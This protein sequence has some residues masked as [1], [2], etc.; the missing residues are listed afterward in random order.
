M[1]V[2]LIPVP[3][4]SFPH[5]KVL[6]EKQSND[7]GS[8]LTTMQIY[9]LF[10]TLFVCTG[11]DAHLSAKDFFT[12]SMS[13]SGTQ[14]TFLLCLYVAHICQLSVQFI[15]HFVLNILS[16]CFQRSQLKRL[17]TL[18]IE[19]VGCTFSN[20]KMSSKITNFDRDP[21]LP[22]FPLFSDFCC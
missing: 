7:F 14:I 13:L 3:F 19:C 9:Q 8:L 17:R 16:I 12:F 10:F 2:K 1:L 6:K 22:C 5:I 4:C 15:N 20:V 11:F 18:I 21:I